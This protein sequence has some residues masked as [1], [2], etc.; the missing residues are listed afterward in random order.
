M[1][2]LAGNSK[3]NATVT[4][5]RGAA[6]WVVA[7]AL[8]WGDLVRPGAWTLFVAASDIYGNVGST[9]VEVIAE[10]YR[11]IA[12]GYK[13]ACAVSGFEPLDILLTE[14]NLVVLSKR[15]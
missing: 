10:P 11:F 9:S 14:D 3:V 4:Y 5:D 1:T 12:E 13:I 7:N 6:V 2:G 15:H 8:S